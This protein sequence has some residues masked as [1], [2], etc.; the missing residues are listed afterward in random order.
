MKV[1]LGAGPA[2]VCPDDLL[3]LITKQIEPSPVYVNDL[4]FT[5]EDDNR[6]LALFEKL[7]VSRDGLARAVVHVS[8]HPPAVRLSECG[9]AFP[10]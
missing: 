8:R 5:G 2:G 9:C 6:F 3:A 4:G 7:L 1:F 10:G